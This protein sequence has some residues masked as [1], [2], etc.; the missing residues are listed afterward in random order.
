MWVFVKSEY[1][2]HAVTGSGSRRFFISRNYGGCANDAGWL[3]VL[4]KTDYCSWGNSTPFPS[5][6][7]SK[8]RNYTNFNTDD[9]GYA[10]VLTVSVKFTVPCKP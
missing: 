10:D 1:K 6:L 5:I 3:A 7:Y 4:D 9:V 8:G 2:K